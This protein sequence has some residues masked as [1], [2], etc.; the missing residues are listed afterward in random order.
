[1]IGTGRVISLDRGYPLVKTDTGEVRAQHSIELV[2]NVDLRSVVGDIVELEFPPGQDTPLITAIRERGH[3]LHRRSLV[4]SR[5]VGSGKYEEQILATNIDVVFVV[6]SLSN[7]HIDVSYL[8]RQLVMAHESGADVAVVLTKADQAKHLEQDLVAV[9]ACAPG[10]EVIAESAVTGEGLERIRELVAGGR[11]GV[12]LGRSGVGK[13]TLINAL[14]KEPDILYK[15]KNQH[16]QL[17]E[18]R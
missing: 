3:T 9:R 7:R 2:K 15:I 17:K 4:E 16:I 10:C 6:S 14:L 5:S 12:L 1:M 18:R 8:E 11:F 13:S